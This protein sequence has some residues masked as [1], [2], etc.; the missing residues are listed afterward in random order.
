VI[1]SAE[2]K[3]LLER[4]PRGNTVGRRGGKIAILE[5]THAVR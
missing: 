4:T 1:S 2:V 3:I 5:N